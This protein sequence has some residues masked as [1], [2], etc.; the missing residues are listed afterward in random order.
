MGAPASPGL[1]PRLIKDLISLKSY[2]LDDENFSRGISNPT[3]ESPS[4]VESLGKVIGC[5][6]SFL[7][8]INLQC[9][10]V[11][12]TEIQD[13]L[14]NNSK[15]VLKRGMDGPYLDKVK[16]DKI[17][18]IE[19][20]NTSLHKVMQNSKIAETNLNQSSSRSHIFYVLEVVRKISFKD[21]E[22][23][24]RICLVDLAGSEKPA[25]A[26][27]GTNRENFH[28]SVKINESLL[29]L[30]KC[31][32]S[33]KNGDQNIPYRECKLT[34][35]LFNYIS[36]TKNII[37]FSNI[38]QDTANLDNTIR[39]LEYASSSSSVNL[40]GL[41]EKLETERKALEKN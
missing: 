27:P 35:V 3:Q 6:R 14:N 12:N 1:I 33:I 38:S 20:M 8:D 22:I 9:F 28:D 37:M 32:T 31:L 40:T 25:R 16:I 41:R 36:S 2:A 26:A 5:P 17:S 34:Q 15:L 11:Y 23:T 21:S 24:R 13:L 4:P 30:G 10:Q 18:D 39:V 29:V 7:F 19:C